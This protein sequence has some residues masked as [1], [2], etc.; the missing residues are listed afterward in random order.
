MGKSREELRTAML[1]TVEAEI[2]QL[3]AWDDETKEV[4]ITD[5]EDQVLAAR[6]RI[7]ARLTEVLVQRR[8]QAAD[9]ADLAVPTDAESGRRLHYKGK[10]T[11]S[12]RRAVGL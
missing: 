12:A 3:L 8:A 9:V 10:K 2:D 6:A 11:K 1:A 5:I 4:T 7:S